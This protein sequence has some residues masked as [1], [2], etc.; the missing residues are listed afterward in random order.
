MEIEYQ[1]QASAEILLNKIRSDGIDY[2]IENYGRDLAEVDI[3]FAKKRNLY[4]AAKH[5]LEEYLDMDYGYEA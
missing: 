4:L 3:T 2:A 5:G 1:K